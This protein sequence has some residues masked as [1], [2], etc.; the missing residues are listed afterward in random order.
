MLDLSHK[1]NNVEWNKYFSYDEGSPSFLVW[2]NPRSNSVK[3]GQN[4]GSLV[5]GSLYYNLSFKIEHKI[6]LL[7]VHRVIWTM[8]YGA[9]P[10]DFVIDHID[11]NTLNN[12]ISNLRCVSRDIS[13]RNKRKPKNNSSGVVGVKLNKKFYRGVC[14][15]YWIA[16]WM[17]DSVKRVKHFRIDKL[18]HDNAFRL[19]CEYRAKMIE[20]LNAQGA[21]YTERHGKPLDTTQQQVL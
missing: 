6:H 16:E 18:G 19:A 20:E 12:D 15:E 4:A 1:T 2:K 17:E 3:I 8:F 21:G 10:K 11:G 14:I 13:A 9:I 5:E 7:K